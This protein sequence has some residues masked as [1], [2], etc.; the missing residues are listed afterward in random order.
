MPFPLVQPG[1]KFK[2][3][4]KLS[5]EVRKLINSVNGFGAGVN[6]GKNNSVIRVPVYNASNT[7]IP[8]GCAVSLV[9]DGAIRGDAYPAVI[10]SEGDICWGVCQTAIDPGK[11]GDC[12]LSGIAAVPISGGTAGT[13]VKPVDD[14][15]FVLDEEEGAPLINI[16]GG[17]IGVA[18]LGNYGR[19]G[20]GKYEGGIGI[21]IVGNTTGD[22][23]TINANIVGVGDIDVTG[24]TDGEPLAIA[25]TGLS[26]GVGYPDYVALAGAT[27]STALGYISDDDYD[28][29]AIPS[30]SPIPQDPAIGVTHIIPVP[31]NRPI[32]YY[33][34]GQG[35]LVR[36]APDA[37]G[38]YH[39]Y[40][41]LPNE[42]EWTPYSKGWLRI[43]VLDDGSHASECMRLYVDG[44]E[45][46]DAVAFH[47]GL[48]Q[49]QGATAINFDV[50]GGTASITLTGGSGAVK[51]TGDGTVAVS[52]NNKN[53]IVLSA[54]GNIGNPD[55]IALAGGTASSSLGSITDEDYEDGVTE[56]TG[57]TVPANPAIGVTYLLPVPANA[58][59]KYY[60]SADCLVRFA[61]YYEVNAGH[62]YHDLSESLEWTPT[63][64]GW[65]RISVLDDGSHSGDCVRVYVDG[66][67]Y[68]DALPLYKCSGFS[69]G[70]ATGINSAVSGGTAASITL[71]GG[72]GSVIIEPANA[73]VTIDGST[74]G[75]IRISATGGGGSGFFPAWS[76]TGH[77]DVLPISSSTWGSGYVANADG[78]IFACAYF[79]P[80]AD[81]MRYKCYDAHVV[82]DG[83]AMKVAELKLPS[84][85]A[86]IKI[87]GSSTKYYREPGDDWSSDPY[88]EHPYYS[89]FAWSAG[90]S[91][92]YTNSV[93]P[94]VGDST[95]IYDDVD[96][97]FDDNH[98]DVDDTNSAAYAVGVGS[99]ITIP[100]RAGATIYYV[101]TA[102]G[103]AFY[104]RFSPPPCFCVFYSSNPPTPAS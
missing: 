13:F 86:F 52:K 72:T 31:G 102:D 44:E 17:T 6:A 16:S 33:S 5:N 104:S 57:S 4:A 79:D 29:G 56:I 20:G 81:R 45:W 25:Y 22:P 100:V 98:A 12:I 3:S 46:S 91:V 71:T 77:T 58:P 82:V 26:S 96:D 97:E 38:T 64:G 74:N 90:G 87:E 41:D 84:G 14:G 11:C 40:Y 39:Y 1:D 2:P 37:G 83:G 9:L 88:A 73:N 95:Y 92:I 35:V 66:E 80:A 48:K 89:Y 28:G 32:K 18:L 101:V 103:N 42:L 63:V 55:Y 59:I 36:Y 85:T 49:K 50:S 70:G 27:Y 62:Y 47:K 53:E 94:V 54:P 21:V 69:G 93:T 19:R 34:N 43:S 67:S 61:P 99:G 10:F 75:R 76:N 8:A 24:G 68:S 78:W 65:L 7:V 30:P 51:V 60:A 15:Y 23:E